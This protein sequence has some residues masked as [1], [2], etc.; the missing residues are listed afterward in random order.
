MASGSRSGSAYDSRT[1]LSRRV[2]ACAVALCG[3][4]EA[5]LPVRAAHA[6]EPSEQAEPGA[7]E[8][9]NQCADAYEATQRERAVGHLLAARK[10]GIFCAQTSC[11]EVLRSDCAK[12]SAE[13]SSSI[14]SLVIEVRSPNGELLSN[15]YV[16]VDGQ[17]F[18]ERLDGRAREIDPGRHHFRFEALG[19]AAHE[20]DTVLLEGH[21]TQRLRVVLALEPVQAPARRRVPVA[22]YVLGG[23]GVLGL[24]SFAYFGLSGNHKKSELDASQCRPACD[25]GLKKPIQNDYLAADLSLGASLVSLGIATWL[26]IAGQSAPSVTHPEQQA[27]RVRAAADGASFTFQ[28]EF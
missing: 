27:L 15:V 21:D 9:K 22:A 7:L 24:G 26:V 5:S 1:S 6:D 18:A 23:V 16:E 20:Q 25:P 2:V 17:P 10:N 3:L 12:W 4:L 8:I 14:P 28:R 11:P 19:L 13:L